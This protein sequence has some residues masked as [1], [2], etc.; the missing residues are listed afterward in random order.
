MSK[1]IRASVYTVEK[2]LVSFRKI[3]HKKEKCFYNVLYIQCTSRSH[4][5]NVIK[6]YCDVTFLLRKFLIKIFFKRDRRCANIFSH[7]VYACVR[8]LWYLKTYIFKFCI[9]RSFKENYDFAR[10]ASYERSS[11]TNN[12]KLIYG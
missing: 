2:H 11:V 9:A 6:I 10:H 5:Q 4:K 1:S 7:N 8:A 3:L 12:I